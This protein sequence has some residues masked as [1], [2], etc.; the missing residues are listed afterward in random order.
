MASPR[1][2]LLVGSML[3]LVAA[4]VASF[5]VSRRVQN[6][7]NILLF[8]TASAGGAAMGVVLV[9]GIGLILVGLLM[10]HFVPPR[11][12]AGGPWAGGGITFKAIVYFSVGY[13]FWG[14]LVGL[15]VAAVIALARKFGNVPY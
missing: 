1:F 10:D 4:A 5:M 14:A 11:P 7:N 8:G 6:R 13:G 3:P 12:G 15:V 2:F 9:C